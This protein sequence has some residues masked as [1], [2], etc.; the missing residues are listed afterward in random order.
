MGRF[1]SLEGRASLSTY[2]IFRCFLFWLG[3]LSQTLRGG[4]IEAREYWD[5]TSRG[6]HIAAK[7][8]RALFNAVK[9]LLAQSFNTR[10]DVFVDNKVLLDS[11]ENKFPNP[12]SSQI[13]SRIYFFSPWLTTFPYSYIMCHLILIRQ[14]NPREFCL[15]SI[16]RSVKICG[17]R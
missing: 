3:C 8:T 2:A 15:T 16:A 12:R 11:G 6:H 9:C 4:P 7:E 1:P 5:E 13:P 10:V 17:N 14:I